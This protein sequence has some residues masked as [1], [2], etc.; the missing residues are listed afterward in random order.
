APLFNI[1]YINHL[2]TTDGW[3]GINAAAGSLGVVIGYLAWERLLRR[4]TFSWAQ[5]RASLF[6]WVFPTVLG[7]IPDLN[8]IMAANLF[9]N[10]MHSGVDLSNFN[11]LLR[12]SQPHERAAYVSWFNA[13]ISVSTFIAPLVGVWIVG[14]IG[15]QYGIQTV[16]VLSGMLRLLGGTLFNINRV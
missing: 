2:H 6:T 15:D 12:I 4:H 9:V 14:L 5:R 8:V 1:Y 10:V 16:L 3:L 13:A 7:L 11:V